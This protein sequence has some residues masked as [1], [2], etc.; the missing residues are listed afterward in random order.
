MYPTERL[1]LASEAAALLDWC[2][3]VCLS[4]CTAL[5][6]S[7]VRCCCCCCTV[8]TF[9][10]RPSIRLFSYYMR[11]WN[12]YYTYHSRRSSF[13]HNPLVETNPVPHRL[14]QPRENLGWMDGWML[15]SDE[16]PLTYS[17]VLSNWSS[18]WYSLA[19]VESTVTGQ[20]AVG[21]STQVTVPMDLI[22]YATFDIGC[23]LQ[24]GFLQ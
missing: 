10:R 2:Q 18:T 7:G 17:T 22:P 15:D 11:I 8:V 9:H 12:F 23:L 13:R 4:F 6:S 20:W 16:G 24:H 21:L 19:G 1:T 5:R 3:S 14:Q